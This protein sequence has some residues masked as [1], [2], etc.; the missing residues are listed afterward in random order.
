MKLKAI[1]LFIICI[2]CLEIHAQT[3]QD[4]LY[5]PLSDI[6][7]LGKLYTKKEL[8]ELEKSAKTG[9]NEVKCE[10]AKYY[11]GAGEKKKAVAIS[12]EIISSLFLL[13]PV[14]IYC[15]WAS[16]ILFEYYKNDN[17]NKTKADKHR[18]DL[19]FFCNKIDNG[20]AYYYV[21]KSY[22]GDVLSGYKERPERYQL[23]Y[24][25]SNVKEYIYYLKLSVL[26]GYDKAEAEYNKAKNE[27]LEYGKELYNLYRKNVGDSYTYYKSIYD[28]YTNNPSYFDIVEWYYTLANAGIEEAKSLYN[29]HRMNLRSAVRKTYGD[30]NVPH[31]DYKKWVKDIVFLWYKDKADKNDP[32]AMYYLA[33]YDD[34]SIYNVD[35]NLTIS[36]RYEYFKKSAEAGYV[37]AQ[38][39]YANLL[40]RDNLMYDAFDWYLKSAQQAYSLS[41]NAVGDS[42]FNG[43]GIEKNK[44]KAL[45]WYHYAAE[46]GSDEAKENLEKLYKEGKIQNSFAT[47]YASIS[48]P[49]NISSPLQIAEDVPEKPIIEKDYSLDKN[50]PVTNA[51]NANT[52]A[53]IIGNENYQRVSK[54]EFALN[55][56]KIFAEYC[57]KTLGLPKNN[58]RSYTDA[59][60]G[61]M[62]TALDDIAQISKAY[63]GNINVIFYYAGH[64]VPDESTKNAF[65]LPVDVDGSKTNLC[66]SVSSL[67]DKLNALNARQVTVFMDACFSGSQRGDGMLVSARGVALKVK[68]DTPQGNMVVFSAATGDQTAF[69]FKEKGHGMITYFLLKKLRDTKGDVTLGELGQYIT[70]NVR[71]QSVVV[72]RRVQ[73]PTVMPAGAL[74]DGWKNI[75]LK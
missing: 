67:Y 56:A 43:Q 23:K 19:I 8:K 39:E 2:F 31:D 58:I 32:E 62:M 35:K 66:L 64:G 45:Q 61:T 24:S 27:Y 69:P 21:A 34:F 12:E 10:L 53:V 51:T 59:T 36:E 5:A 70:D 50:I 20:L 33:W 47:W 63:N 16:Y 22:N 1:V 65:L 37:P 30:L 73:T 6:F 52:F 42:Y 44:E 26:K 13:K 40:K 11:W 60:Y 75:K 48:N 7:T 74:G 25:L 54:V 72:N 71:Q 57:Q 17:P 49:D 38:Y 28:M 15:C 41:A 46:L 14:D 9:S 68:N 18:K 29:Q 55:D 3:E 4:N